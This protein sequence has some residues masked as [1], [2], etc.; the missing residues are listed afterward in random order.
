MKGARCGLAVQSQG[1][2][3]LCLPTRPREKG[4]QAHSDNKVP[5]NRGL[6]EET[7]KTSQR[8]RQ[9]VPEDCFLRRACLPCCCCCWC[10]WLASAQ[11]FPHGVQ[12]RRFWH[13]IFSTVSLC[14]LPAFST[15]LKTSVGNSALITSLRTYYVM[16]WKVKLDCETIPLFGLIAVL[17]KRRR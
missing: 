14:C 15:F 1:G 4:T 12:A 8:F 2:S 11:S 17:N 6:G 16:A 5:G 7:G 9:N 3:G 10:S 13:L